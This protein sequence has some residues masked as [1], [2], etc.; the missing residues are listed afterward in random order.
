[1]FNR[2]QIAKNFSFFKYGDD[3]HNGRGAETNSKLSTLY[4][5][6]LVVNDNNIHILLVDDY[7][8]ATDRH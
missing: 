7:V 6:Q 4:G 1:M 2:S 5:S 3:S 8:T